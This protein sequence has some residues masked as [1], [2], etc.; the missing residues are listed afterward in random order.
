MELLSLREYR[1]GD[2]ARSIAWKA[3]ARRGTPIV[4]VLSR[5]EQGELWLLLD[6]GRISAIQA[7]ALTRLHHYAN[8]A[9][10]LA[11][12]AVR[13]GDRVGLM[14]FADRPLEILP[15]GHGTQAL[16]MI[17]AILE[18]TRSQPR[19]SNS[20]AALME[21]SRIARHRTLVVVFS[22]IEAGEAADQLVRGIRLLTPKHLPVTASLVDPDIHALA[23]RE[24]KGWL[25]PYES[26][27]ALEIT[28]SQRRTALHL[29]RLG[30]EVVLA[31]PE[32]L[33]R[34]VLRH[35]AELRARRRI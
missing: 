30:A 5:E 33:D 20:L 24:P 9:A 32:D 1:P 3:T 25:D 4:R 17:R 21:M 18:H 11:Q 8:V 34:E 28:F 13:Q 19:E 14:V 27:A 35:Y 7:G 22:E 26:L 6:A 23:E 29:Y 12:K 2:P 10:R 31:R 16:R 15:P